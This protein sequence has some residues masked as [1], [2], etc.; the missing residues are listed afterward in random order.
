MEGEMKMN[1]DNKGIIDRTK[2][3]FALGLTGTN[4]SL[5]RFILLNVAD[6]TSPES[7]LAIDGREIERLVKST[8][9]SGKYLEFD[10]LTPATP[11]PEPRA[12]PPVVP[13]LASRTGTE[14]P[15]N[16]S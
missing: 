6:G 8:G 9:P 5:D 2:E 1:M 16:T 7:V 4:P 3:I 11:G 13:A 10:W 15:Q 12:N 14:E